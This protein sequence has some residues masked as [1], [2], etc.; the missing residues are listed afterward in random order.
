MKVSSSSGRV[1][2]GGGGGG[3]CGNGGED[4]ND[5]GSRGDSGGG[6][7]GAPNNNNSST[8]S[9]STCTS[10]PP[11]SEGCGGGGGGGSGGSGLVAGVLVSDQGE[12]ISDRYV[13][14]ARQFASRQ[15][16]ER[17]SNKAD[18]SDGSDDE[19]T[20]RQM[21]VSLQ[22]QVTDMSANLTTRLDELQSRGVS[23]SPAA[24]YGTEHRGH[25]ETS[26]AL[27][28]IRTQLHELTRSLESCQSEV[29]E[30]KRDM[31]AIKNELD[32]VQQVKEEIEELREYV[33]RLELQ[34]H[35]RKLRLLEQGLTFFLSY[36]ILAS[37][38]G[39]LQ[40]GY[41]TGVINAPEGN[42]EKFIK[43]VF[44]DRYKEN[45][46]HAQAELLYSFA[47]SIFAIGGMLGGFSGG[48]IAN[49]FGRKG[50]LLLNSF[51]GIGGACLMGL[52]KYFNS[53]E[54]L[55]IGRFIIGVNCGLNTSLV[56]M[57]ISEIAPLNLRG[58]LGTVNQLAVTTGLLISQIL[59]IEQILGTDEGWPLLLG[60]A[61]CPAIL[62]LILLPVCPESP[63]YLLI[64]KQWEEEARK[65]L[66]RLRATN[67]IEE[68]IE[69]MRAE[70]RA[71]QS[72]ATISMM[73][74]VCSPTLRQPL[75]ISVVMQLSQQL[76]GIN[77]VFYY[78]TSLFITAGLAENVA[79][80]VTIGIGVI[81]VN[82]TLVT[83]PLM[84]KTGRR[85][86]HLYGLGGMFIFSIFITIS[87]LITEMID[88]M[89]YLAVVSILGFVVFFAVG[90]GSI[91]WM[92]TA[93]LF[94][95]GPRPAAMSIA[96][97]INWVANF[98][99]GIGFQPLKT[100]LDNYTFLPFSVLLAIFWIFT[101]KKVPETKNKT[102]EEI[103]A[104]FRQNGRG[105]VLE[106]SRLYGSMLNYSNALDEHLPPSERASLMVAEEKPLPDSSPVQHSPT[107][108]EVCAVCVNTGSS[109][110]MTSPNVTRRSSHTLS[111]HVCQM[112]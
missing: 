99:V 55:F 70:E 50:G 60:L 3:V 14:V 7:G 82:M 76:S 94:S 59:G 52:T 74:L 40:F 102:F 6:G 10:S 98:A 19:T 44:E 106:S 57:Y 49:R 39:M 20:L 63:R 100:A 93:E 38:L 12:V 25:M 78:S 88:W 21:L 11:C 86:L 54:V 34:S 42:I 17:G 13:G 62:Q 8:S 46:D 110:M 29:T 68:D 92:I 87:L 97:L 73:E 96:V 53:Y 51:V 27:S 23:P 9:T 107:D 79:K 4:G 81:M 109:L 103:L 36:T 89:S 111:N 90:P 112:D 95:Q 16:S 61:I 33:D 75:I 58:G 71:Q 26:V 47:V 65:A 5:T 66:R 18:Q 67:Q 72:E 105:S 35:R 24:Y 69:E 85:T 30:V 56:P 32:T 48:I 83:M 28:E 77:A 91:P 1:C 15:A 101:Y 37:M 41:N 22:H 2:G 104:L 108:Q 43:D 80:F 31:V 84:D 45:M 64:T